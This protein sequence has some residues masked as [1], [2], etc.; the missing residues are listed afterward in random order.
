VDVALNWRL[1]LA[2]V[3]L[4]AV[5]G[6]VSFNTQLTVPTK[7]NIY[8][9]VTQQ[10]TEYKHTLGCASGVACSAY[11]YQAFTTLGYNGG[12]LSVGLRWNYYP[13]IKAADAAANP[14]TRQR[15]VIEPYNLFS[16]SGSY[17]LSS[18]LMLRAG[19]DNMFNVEPPLSGGAYAEDGSF[20]ATVP[21]ALATPALPSA[22]ARYDQLG[23][24]Y[25]AGFTLKL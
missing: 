15:G 6:A 10:W 2:D 21:P 22:D 24:R 1:Q 5:P 19:I 25:F 23:R 11:K 7:R 8:S 14:A 12:P 18:T 16:L 9:A 20:W 3:G 13:S 4:Q 17:E